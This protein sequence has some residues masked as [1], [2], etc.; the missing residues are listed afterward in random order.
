[1]IFKSKR[2]IID[3]EIKVKIDG[4]RLTP[5]NF[6]KYLGIFIDSNLEWSFHINALSAKLSRAVGLLSKIRHYVS[7]ETLRNIYFAIFSSLLHYS[8]I[9]WGQTSSRHIK[10]IET[11][12]NKALKI[13]N[14]VPFNAQTNQQYKNSGILKFSD[15][16][17]LSNF[18]LVH[19]TINRNIPFALLNSFTPVGNTHH[20]QTR[21]VT[22]QKVILP[23]IKKVTYGENSISYQAAKFWNNM[24]TKYPNKE[25]HLK[26]K[27]FCKKFITNKLIET[28]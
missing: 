16:I 4:K 11:I 8:S 21:G 18:L 15:Q 23:R 24:V 22:N 13:I 6:I 14:S 25:L 2:K 10:R 19:E 12:Q 20:H 3:F 9:I 28:Y 1:M 7:K 17:K 26:S 5:V 27:Q